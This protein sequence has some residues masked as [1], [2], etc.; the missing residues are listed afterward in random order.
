M[1][2]LLQERYATNPWKLLVSCILLNQTSR[3]QVDAVIDAGLFERFPTPQ[4]MAFADREEIADAVRHLGFGN[5]RSARLH[6][7]ST[8]WV[9]YWM[10]WLKHPTEDELRRFTG[11]GPYA[12]DSYRIFWL[13]DTSRCDSG[14]KEILAWAERNGVEWDS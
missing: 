10:K 9:D 13:G 4:S 11:I 2:E 6:S 8:Q 14:D 7:F 1:D 5:V 3:R 12:L